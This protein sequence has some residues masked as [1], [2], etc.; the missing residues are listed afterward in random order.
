MTAV[1]VVLSAKWI[2]TVDRVWPLENGRI[3]H[4]KQQ[5]KKGVIRKSKVT[6]NKKSKTVCVVW[7]MILKKTPT[8]KF[9]EKTQRFILVTCKKGAK[10]FTRC[11]FFYHSVQTLTFSEKPANFFK[12]NKPCLVTI[13]FFQNRVLFKPKTLSLSKASRGLFTF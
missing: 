11:T 7:E 9:F 4:Q 3:V 8:E 10:L 2:V 12:Q 13:N 5:Q 6:L 1:V